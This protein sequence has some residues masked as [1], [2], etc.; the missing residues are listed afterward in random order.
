MAF[1]QRKLDAVRKKRRVV[2]SQEKLDEVRRSK[3]QQKQQP[4]PVQDILQRSLAT[5]PIAQTAQMGR[6]AGG[7][8]LGALGRFAQSGAVKVSPG[9][10]DVLNVVDVPRRVGQAAGTA[11]AN[12][13]EALI[14]GA[15]A[16]AGRVLQAGQ[17]GFEALKPGFEPEGVAEQIGAGVGQI[18]PA[19]ALATALPGSTI[20]SL[21]GQ[22]AVGGLEVAAMQA[23]VSGEISVP[24]VATAVLAPPIVGAGAKF[25]AARKGIKNLAEAEA[26]IESQ[27]DDLVK[28]YNKTMSEGFETARKAKSHL[29]MKVTEVDRQA[30]ADTF[31]GPMSVKQINDAV[32]D[33]ITPPKPKTIKTGLL[34]A[35]GRPLTKTALPITL[36]PAQKLKQLAVLDEQINNKINYKNPVLTKVES[37]VKSKIRRTML[38]TGT[39]EAKTFVQISLDES[40][41]ITTMK[42]LKDVLDGPALARSTIERIVNGTI[43]K[44]LTTRLG[45]QIKAISRL[46][47]QA[48][49]EFVRPLRESIEASRA[50]QKELPKS[51]KAGNIARNLLGVASPRAKHAAD[52]IG[53]IIK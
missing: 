14:P 37:S 53:S 27:V 5:T 21:V 30:I 35:K 11:L 10:R 22:G 17:R 7:S 23:S 20:L 24:L 4:G 33:I 31:G 3:Q 15:P 45:K 25:V 36:S 40:K 8:V 28:T 49:R 39:D 26:L 19:A 41:L 52:L 29:N 16:T 12:F 48:K 18:V 2:F 9:V 1:D 38:E 44:N 43:K 32:N 34:D 50:I 47:A 13:P 51:G 46:E 42:A 6:K